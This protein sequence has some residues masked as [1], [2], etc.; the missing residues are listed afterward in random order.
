MN[1]RRFFQFTALCGAGLSVF[2]S[3]AMPA[4]PKTLKKAN[5]MNLSAFALKNYQQVLG[6]FKEDPLFQSDP[7]YFEIG[8]NFAFGEVFEATP[9]ID[10]PMRLKMILGASLAT[11]GK[12]TFQTFLPAA[13]RNGVSAIHIKEII[14]Q[15]SAYIGTAQSL[16]F[17]NDANQ[18][19]LKNN[20]AL[21]LPS[22]KTV[23][24]ENRQERGLALQR[25]LF[26]ETIDQNNAAA[27]KDQQHIR[28]FLS[29]HCFGD[30][31]TREGLD[32]HFREL[33]TLVILVSLGGV[34]PQMKAH[35]QGNFHIGRD[36][37]F[38]IQVFTALLPYIGYPKTLNAFNALN[39]LS[40][41]KEK[42]AQ[43]SAFPWSAQDFF[44]KFG[45]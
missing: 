4:I 9:L 30:F 44:E 39:A 33:L 18:Y 38:L 19:F 3:P 22:Q 2:A 24:L 43:N 26:G 20:I 34:E 11:Q 41:Q 17:L 23:P 35:I 27:P 12:D 32:L 37:N 1:R 45:A 31:Y 6:D 7:D 28:H 15:S 8:V 29:R 13:L 40:P 5:K 42:L 36:R 16:D 14:Y 10:L 21:P 25:Q